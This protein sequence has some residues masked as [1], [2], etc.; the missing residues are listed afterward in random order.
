MLLAV[1]SPPET[2]NKEVD[3]PGLDEFIKPQ[4]NSQC[5]FP[6]AFL[7]HNFDLKPENEE[8]SPVTVL[9][10]HFSPV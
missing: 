1:F 7:E 2:V 5:R 4:Q 6:S 10:P 9:D 3:R 8:P